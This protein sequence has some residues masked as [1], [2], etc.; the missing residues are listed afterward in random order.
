MAYWDTT[1]GMGRAGTGAV[2]R[3]AAASAGA[4]AM[5]GTAGAGMGMAA[6]TGMADMTGAAGMTGAAAARKA[7]VG[8]G[9]K[10]IWGIHKRWFSTYVA[11]L[12]FIHALT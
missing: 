9:S 8:D 6:T 11:I 2:M 7:F 12:D 1:A 4:A 3:G 10:T 5:A